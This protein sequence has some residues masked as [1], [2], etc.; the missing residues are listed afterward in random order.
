MSVWTYKVK[1]ATEL[2]LKSGSTPNDLLI[3]L[4]QLGS[5]GWELA[6][7]FPAETPDSKDFWLVFKKQ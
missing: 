6:T 4:I 7:I 1:T 2:G 5:D 3:Q